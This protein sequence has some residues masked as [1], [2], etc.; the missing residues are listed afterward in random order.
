M[1]LEKELE[2]AIRAAVR[3]GKQILEVYKGHFEVN[4]K[5]DN[6]P[7]TEAD[8]KA[9]DVIVG[10]IQESFPDHGILSEESAE[11][12]SKKN[13]RC[14]WV[15]DPLDGTKEFVKKN[16][17][18]TVNIALTHSG[19]VVMGVVYAPAF[20][21]LYYGILG[22]GAWLTS[23]GKTKKISVSNRT[24]EL[25]ILQS[26]SP[27]SEKCLE[28]IEKNKEKIGTITCMGSAL[29][30]CRIA[31]GEYDVYYNC[32]RTMIWD[33]CAM[34]LIVKEAGGFLSQ[35]DGTD[36]VYD[37]KKMVNDKGFYILNALC[38]QF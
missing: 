6:S 37:L 5:K 24:E 30:G 33:T 17:E 1:T 29:K 27:Q 9:H 15:V 38:N 26:R 34:E 2:V 11:N 31:S 32:G 4:F 3:A 20:E 23:K 12:F 35:L 7:L 14:C 18:F 36:I 10:T 8:L 28:Y 25:S 22:E 19:T 13:N 16:D 21:E